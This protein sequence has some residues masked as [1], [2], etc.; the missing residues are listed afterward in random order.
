MKSLPLASSFGAPPASASYF[1]ATAKC[2][3]LVITTS[4]VGTACII[5]RCAISRCIWRT[6]AFTSGLPSLSL[7]SSRISCLVIISFL[8]LSQS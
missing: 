8:R 6:L 1:S 2:V 5:R 3:G 7:Y 4:A